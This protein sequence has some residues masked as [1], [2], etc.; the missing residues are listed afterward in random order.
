MKTELELLKEWIAEQRVNYT[1][2]NFETDEKKLDE[3][4]RQQ[5]L[6]EIQMQILIFEKQCTDAFIDKL[7]N[8]AKVQVVATNDTPA[9]YMHVGK[10]LRK[11][12]DEIFSIRAKGKE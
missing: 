2:H 10:D 4:V 1:I 3:I 9:A 6:L 11:Q 7:V 8:E 5:T 12:L